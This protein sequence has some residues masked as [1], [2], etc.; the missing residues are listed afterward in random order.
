VAPDTYGFHL[1]RKSTVSSCGATVGLSLEAA[2]CRVTLSDGF[3]RRVRINGAVL[4]GRN[5]DLPRVH[6]AC[7][8]HEARRGGSP[9]VPRWSGAGPPER[10]AEAPA[11]RNRPQPGRAG[12]SRPR[13]GRRRSACRH[14]RPPVGLPLSP[15]QGRR[16]SSEPEPGG[17][18]FRRSGGQITRPGGR[19]SKPG[20]RF[21]WP[22]DCDAC[23]S[24][25]TLEA[26]V[27]REAERARRP[28]GG[29]RAGISR[30]RTRRGITSGVASPER[31]SRHGRES[32]PPTPDVLFARRAKRIREGAAEPPGWMGCGGCRWWRRGVASRVPDRR[33]GRP[34]VPTPVGRSRRGLAHRER[35]SISRCVAAG[36]RPSDR[37]NNARLGLATDRPSR[38]A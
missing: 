22:P 33:P 37:D 8:T 10:P 38:S 4:R 13:L 1:R 28:E 20:D 32:E 18:P 6:S 15:V 34:E 7:Q 35:A 23:R 19:H 27:F 12:P 5:D 14:G 36:M 9:P 16:A 24:E 21:P 31:I 17:P 29:R 25:Q 11:A 2:Q 3:Q 30:A 26:S